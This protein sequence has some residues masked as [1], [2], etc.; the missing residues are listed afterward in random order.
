MRLN[1]VVKLSLLVGALAFATPAWPGAFTA[2]ISNLLLYETGDLVYIYVE[3]GTQQRP[4][5]AGSNG[6]YLSFSMA[7][8]R[9]KQYLAALM[10]A[11]TTGKSVTFVTHGAC[12]DQNVSDTL[13]FL[14]LNN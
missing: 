10:L 13:W 6:D 4:A 2:R 12:I 9:A 14:Q 8:P 5:C 1:K 11:F 3:G 7:R